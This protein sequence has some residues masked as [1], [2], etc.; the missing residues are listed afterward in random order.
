MSIQEM[1]CRTPGRAPA[2]IQKIWSI[3]NLFAQF[4]VE[5]KERSSA[6]QFSQ[7]VDS[8]LESVRNDRGFWELIVEQE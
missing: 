3:D 8:A 5:I 2:G 1:K 7:A 4:P 6:G